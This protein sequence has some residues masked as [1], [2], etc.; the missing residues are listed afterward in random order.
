MGAASVA[1]RP[2]WRVAAAATLLV[3]SLASYQPTALTFAVVVVGGEVLQILSQG[4]GYWGEARWRWLEV[5]AAT[6]A[7]VAVYLLSVRIVWWATGTDPLTVEA[8]DR[9]TGGYPS[10]AGRS[11][12]RCATG[13]DDR[14]VLVR[15]YHAV[16]ARPQAGES[17]VGGGRDPGSHAGGRPGRVENQWGGPV[18]RTWML[19][20][21]L[22][23]LVVPFVVLFMR[24]QPPT[25]GNVFTTVGLV[26]GFWAG[27]LLELAGAD[28][29]DAARPSSRNCRDC[30]GP[31]GRPGLR[32]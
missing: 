13:A 11:R 31:G 3:V 1:G 5:A 15:W 20:L 22:G 29:A 27:L 19:L 6:V 23:S 21:C 17:R 18:A 12:V 7:G 14:A 9:L 24:E 25:R 16:P 32:L 8:R 4:R 28:A 10:T 26:I 2:T 30:T